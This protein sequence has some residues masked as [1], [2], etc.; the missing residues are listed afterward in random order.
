MTDQAELKYTAEHEWVK[1]E[2][3]TVT[4][5]I[6]DYAAEKLGDVV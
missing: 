2:G 4:I 1:V 5:G 3:D 6:T